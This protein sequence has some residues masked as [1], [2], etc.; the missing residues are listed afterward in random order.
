MNKNYSPIPTAVAVWLA[1]LFVAAMLF[2]LA[3]LINAAVTASSP[4][5]TWADFQNMWLLMAEAQGTIDTLLALFMV[6]ITVITRDEHDASACAPKL[7]P[8]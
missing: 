1:S 5:P 6:P 8:I 7:R 3:T 2:V 4:D